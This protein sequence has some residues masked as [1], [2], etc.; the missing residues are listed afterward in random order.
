MKY[1]D[2]IRFNITLKIFYPQQDVKKMKKSVFN[3]VSISPAC[4][5]CQH[6]KPHSKRK[7][8]FQLHIDAPSLTLG[9]MRI[10]TI[11]V[12]IIESAIIDVVTNSIPCISG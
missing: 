10:Q 3:T 7:K 5:Y 9:S 12:V 11:S 1:C 2:I 4:A 6:G 8:S